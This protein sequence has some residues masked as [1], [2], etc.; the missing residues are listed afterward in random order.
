MVGK[1]LSN[2]GYTNIVGI[3][4]AEDMLKLAEGKGYKELNKVFLCNGTF[5]EEYVGKFDVA[6]S[7]GLLVHHLPSEILDEKISCLRPKESEDD[8]RYIIFATRE[9]CMEDYGYNK[10]LKELED[11]GKIKFVESFSWTRYENLE[12]EGIG[13]FRPLPATCYV[14]SV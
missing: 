14:Y 1:L 13:I 8:K 4:G 10:K 3:D 2:L 11:E 7:A 5:P 6:V 9:V 12:K